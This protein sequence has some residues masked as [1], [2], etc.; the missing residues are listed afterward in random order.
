MS[1]EKFLKNLGKHIKELREKKGLS[2]AE[3]ARRAEMERSHIA[4]LES[5][6]TNP[7]STTLKVICDA[8]DISFEE[9]F[10]GFNKTR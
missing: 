10:K 2:A 9:L 6:Q 3:F 5:G 8:L 1:K 7:T 4:R